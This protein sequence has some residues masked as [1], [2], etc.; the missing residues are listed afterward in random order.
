MTDHP[1]AQI[2]ADS[3]VSLETLTFHRPRR[4]PDPSDRPLARRQFRQPRS[5]ARQ[6]HGRRHRRRLRQARHLAHRNL[7]E[8]P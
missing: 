3:D 8:T 5:V 4:R 6:R 1:Q 7:K 2:E